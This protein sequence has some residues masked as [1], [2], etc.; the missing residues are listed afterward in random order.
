MTHQFSL[1]PGFMMGAIISQATA[2]LAGKLNFYDALLIQDG[3]E[4]HKIRPPLDLESWQNL[5]VWAIATPRPVVLGG[6]SEDEL[7]GIT[8]RFPYNSFPLVVEGRLCGIVSRDEILSAIQLGERPK[9]HEATV[10]HP[11]QTVREVVDT[12]IGSSGNVLVVDR[13]DGNVWG[14]ITLRDLIRAQAAIRS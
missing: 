11:E 14:I 5:D 9:V 4:F 13:E 12:F 2:R 8:D 1:V 3:H 7:Q 10:C 6:L